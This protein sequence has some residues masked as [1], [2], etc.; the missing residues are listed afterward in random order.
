MA[1]PPNKSN[2]RAMLKLRIITAVILL[3]AVVAALYFLP[4][5]YF[6]LFLGIFIVFAAW[7]WATLCNIESLFGKVTYVISIIFIAIFL[8]IGLP[9]IVNGLYIVLTMTVIWW[10]A[11][12]LGIINRDVDRNAVLFSNKWLKLISGYLILLPAWLA[13]IFLHADDP[14]SPLMLLLLFAI[15]WLAD[16][17]AYLTGRKWGKT[18]LAAHASPG[19]TVEGFFGG[20]VAILLFALTVG[21]I[22]GFG[23]AYFIIWITTVVITG[24]F[25]VL[26]DLTE[27]KFKRVAGVKDSGNLLP[28]HGGVL[29][30]IDALTAAAPIYTLAWLLFLKPGS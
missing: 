6:A 3:V 4:T 30:R 21:F 26:G 11:P 18:K 25:S 7:E 17:A 23:V 20:M 5:P 13:S 1:R 29:D 12:L 14:D 2:Q 8:Y 24:L 16:S 10:L 9:R 27:S 19:K 28:G 22:K 15:V